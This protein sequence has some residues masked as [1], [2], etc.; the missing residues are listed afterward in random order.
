MFQHVGSAKESAAHSQIEM[1]G[2]ALDT[3]RLQVG[4][5]PSTAEGLRA[6][7][8]RPGSV[9]ET[10]WRGPYLRRDVPLDP[11]GHEYVY[12]SPGTA[13]P[14]GYDLVSFGADRVPG[15]KGE[16]ADIRSW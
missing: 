15:G 10:A 5:Y 6:L 8:E 16:S 3:Y 13:N 12:S 1:F 4:A 7:R 2:V 11:W 14:L 9:P